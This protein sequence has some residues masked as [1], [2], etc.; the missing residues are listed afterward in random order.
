MRL[1]LNL[2]TEPMRRDRAILVAS[3]AVGVLLC[4]TLV[5][6]I[7]LQL[8]DRN[9]MADTR[10]ALARVRQQL[11]SVNAEQAKFDAQT[12]LPQN[13]S[14][15]L[16]SELYNALIRRKAISWTR[17]FSDLETVLPY[18]VRIVSIRPQLNGRNELALDMVVAAPTPDPIIGFIAK[19]ETSDLFGVLTQTSQT[20]PTQTDPMFRFHFTVMYDQ[21][22]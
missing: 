12:R 1:P 10:V 5:A 19:L 17:I 2:A 7:W 6:L 14:L 3:G 11:N 20:P 9:T 8:T 18:D 4:V 16:R 21:K 13:A 15:L 22:L